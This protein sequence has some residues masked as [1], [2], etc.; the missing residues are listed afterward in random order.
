[1]P[2]ESTH[3]VCIAIDTG[4]SAAHIGVDDI[5]H[6]ADAGFGEGRFAE[7]SFDF[8]SVDHFLRSYWYLGLRVSRT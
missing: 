3:E 1:M 4:M 6:A 7:D 2:G 8:H 5:V